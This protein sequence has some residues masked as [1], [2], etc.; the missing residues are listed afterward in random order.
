MQ[1]YT[2]EQE[3]HCSWMAALS[4]PNLA[5]LNHMW[6]KFAL[7]WIVTWEVKIINLALAD[8]LQVRPLEAVGV[9]FMGQKGLA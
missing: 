9:I 6:P 3:L 5:G 2:D 4:A 8:T 1:G 7:G